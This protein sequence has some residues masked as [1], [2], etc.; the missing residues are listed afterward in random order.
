MDKNINN[1]IFTYIQFLCNNKSIDILDTILHRSLSTNLPLHKIAKTTLRDEMR[2]ILSLFSVVNR[3]IRQQ[4][5]S[6]RKQRDKFI[7]IS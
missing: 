2:M 7:T 3:T 4:V 6:V 5:A 1:T